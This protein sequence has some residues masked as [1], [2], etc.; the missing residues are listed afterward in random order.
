LLTGTLAVVTAGPAVAGA[1]QAAPAGP[2]VGHVD[3][4]EISGLI[5][6]IN[7]DFVLHALTSAQ[8]DGALALVMR[9]NS[10]G[11][12]ISTNR[13]DALVFRIAHSPVPVAAW[14]GPTGAR[15]L[16]AGFALVDAAGVKGAAP[17]T[18]LGLAPP[19]VFG[20]SPPSPLADR[21]VSGDR[22]VKDGVVQLG[23]STLGDFILG[24]D[25]Q[26]AGGTVLHIPSHVVAASG[27]GTPHRAP[28]IQ[29]R[30]G[31]LSLVA[32]LLHTVA[33][34][35]VTYLL[36]LVGLL[37]AVL[38]FYT[39]GIGI[40]AVVAAGCLVLAGYGIGVLPVRPGGIALLC[41]AIFGYAIDLQA[42]T[43]RTWTIIGTL[44]L[45]A[46][47][48]LLYP[49]ARP[50]SL[51]LLV[52][53]VGP[54]LFMVAGMP[55]MVRSRFSTPTIGRESMIGE[56]GTALADVSPEGTVEIRGAPWRARTNR[57]TPITAGAPVRVT[58]IDGL[59]L[60]VEPEVGGAREA[61]H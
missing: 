3:V 29:A 1:P 55:A 26:A 10:T 31:R 19:P 43:P 27:G 45:V 56:M 14:V 38:E 18:H 52:G 46:G 4:I 9:V 20:S 53:L 37:L 24:L 48:F 51:A 6:P 35:S 61:R 33:S 57:A 49:G 23:S 17:G 12:T 21:V 50:A 58:G 47:S 34:R 32:T 36:L 15:A 22:A 5:D 28:D 40:G 16:R 25:G 30:F 44:C 13:L 54:P 2:A 59:L 11:S 8:R 41:I 60:E 42:G 39:A 7:E